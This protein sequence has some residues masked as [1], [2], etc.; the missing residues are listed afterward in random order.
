MRARTLSLLLALPLLLLA[1]GPA[2]GQD[3]EPST[4]QPAPVTSPDHARDLGAFFSRWCRECHAPPGTETDLRA[5]ADEGAS[6]AAPHLLRLVQERLAQG[7]MPPDDAPAPPPEAREAALR[8]IAAAAPP[9]PAPRVALRRLNRQEYDRAV[10][11]LLGVSCRP[12]RDSFP[13]DDVGHGFDTVGD[14]LGVSPLLVEKLQRAAERVAAE[15]VL[16]WRPLKARVEAERMGGERQG[17]L[18]WLYSEGELSTELQVP[19]AGEYRLRVRAC[20]DQAGP[21]PARMALRA[22]ERE[23]TRVEVAAPR[24]APQVYELRARL[25]AGRVRLGL[26]FVNDYYRPE[27]PDPKQ[28]DRNLGVDWV[29]VE[30]P[31]SAPQLPPFHAGVVDRFPAAGADPRPAARELLRPLLRRATRGQAGPAELE[32][33]VELLAGAVADGEGFARGLQLALEALL[34]SPRFLFRLERDPDPRDPSPH[35]VSELELAARLSFFLWGSLPDERLLDLAEAGGLRAGLAREARRMLDDPRASA[36]TEDFA[37]QWLGLRRLEEVTPDPATYPDFDEELRAAMRAE[38]ELL[39]EAVLREDRGALDL[40]AAPFTFLNE[41]LARHYGVSGVE[42]PRFRRVP[43]PS[44][45]AG[46]LGHASLLT[47]TSNPTRTSP[48]KRGKLILEQ[49]LDDPP[50]PPPPGAGDLPDSREAAA[51]ASLRER[52]ARHRR[53]AACASCHA[54]MDA[55]GLGLERFDGIGALRTHDEGGFP[56][57]DQAELPGGA[58]LAGPEGLREHLRRSGRAFVRAL[59]GKLLVYGVGRGLAPGDE[60]ELR[61]IVLRLERDEVPWRFQALL[62]S[63]VETRAF[64]SR[65]GELE[66]LEGPW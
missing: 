11:D 32:R 41:R 46:I 6:R 59:L 31:V 3:P 20:G 2:G 60:A 5:L 54:R 12:G 33:L 17:R 43:A 16:V 52:L 9:P 14:V 25:P 27:D 45:R 63:L 65:R 53:E 29:E 66:S 21:D 10:R 40:I 7:E 1:R 4:A 49:L 38:T 34:V 47:L 35:L 18:A 30:G 48:V 24:E 61:A 55:L 58:R 28:R 36:L 37:G 22:A 13:R 42:G 50:P 8:W 56:I 15:A 62:V 23:L 26:A 44:G 19:V 39:F 64:Q 57:D 51:R